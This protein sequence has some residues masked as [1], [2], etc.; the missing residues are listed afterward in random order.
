MESLDVGGKQ[1]LGDLLVAG[2]SFHD[3]G[4]E[5]AFDAALIALHDGRSIRRRHIDRE[6]C[7]RSV[8]NAVVGS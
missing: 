6:I 5:V 2:M 4:H 8:F 7:K 3:A 1:K